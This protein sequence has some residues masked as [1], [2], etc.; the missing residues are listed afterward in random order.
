MFI[1]DL[2]KSFSPRPKAPGKAGAWPHVVVLGGGFAGVGTVRALRRE[3]V[4]V[5][6]VDRNVYKTFQPLLFQVATAGL[7]PGDVTMSLRSFSLRSPNLR[8]WQGNV[9]GIDHEAREVLMADGAHM[10][11][12]HLVIASGAT[13]NFFGTPGAAENAMPMYTRVQAVAIR[14]RIFQELER[15]ARRSDGRRLRVS[16][17]GGGPTGVEI[18]GAL[19]DFRAQELDILYPEIDP[20]TLEITLLQRGK[21]L[22]KPY[23]AGSRR[24]AAKELEKR[25]VTLRLGL[26]VE[27]VGERSIKLADGS[28]VPSDITIWAAG[29]GVDEAVANWGLPQGKGGRV[30]TDEYLRVKGL[31]NTYAAGDI[32]LTPEPLPQLAQPALQQGAWVGENIARELRGEPAEPFTYKNLGIMAT[33]GRRAALAEM[34]GLPTLSGSVGWLAWILVHVKAMLGHRNRKAVMSNL[35]SLYGGTRSS[36][37]PNPILG[38]IRSQGKPQN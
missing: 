14:D 34:P 31:K 6:L 25:G 3:R 35:I 29:V 10:P 22:L 17:V 9:V 21:E 12:D 27:E 11:Y 7:N 26:G 4:Q 18:A 1:K 2:F 36:H 8:F 37:Q 38:D 15:A 30:E 19:A 24:Y 32:A 5:T 33:I 13:T 23:R 28:S 20:G 16:I